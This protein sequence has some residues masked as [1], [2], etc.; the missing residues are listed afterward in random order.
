MYDPIGNAVEREAQGVI[1]TEYA[2]PDHLRAVVHRFLHIRTDR[3]LL[4]NHR[5][6]ALPDACTYLIFDQTNPDICGLT[7][8]QASSKALS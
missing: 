7:R 3:P 1:F 8:L 6:H 2:P 4:E 5:F